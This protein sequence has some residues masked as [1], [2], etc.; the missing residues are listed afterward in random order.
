MEKKIFGKI[1]AL[2]LLLALGVGALF[3]VAQGGRF[4]WLVVGGREAG[5]VLGVYRASVVVDFAGVATITCNDDATTFTVAGASIGDVVMVSPQASLTPS[6]LA[7]CRVSAAD[8]VTC[9]L[10]NPTAGADDPASA[11][12]DVVVI[13]T[14]AHR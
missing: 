11:T 14:A 6:G 1:A 10:C 3:T 5:T 2:V 8:T 4:S 7:A 12:Y 13:R 9:G